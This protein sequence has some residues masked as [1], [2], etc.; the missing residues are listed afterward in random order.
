MCSWIF[1]EWIS[2]SPLACHRNQWL[3]LKIRHCFLY[4]TIQNVFLPH[5]LLLPSSHRLDC[6]SFLPFGLFSALIICPFSASF[7]FDLK[8]ACFPPFCCLNSTSSFRAGHLFHYSM[9]LFLMVMFNYSLLLYLH[10]F[11]LSSRLSA[12]QG[13][14]SSLSF[15]FPRTDLTLC[16]SLPPIHSTYIVCP[17]RWR[18]GDPQRWGQS[19][20]AVWL[21]RMG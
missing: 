20:L 7:S 21:F 3:S 1:I 15:S 6:K 4:S 17:A 5:P 19:C 9:K 13:Q 10:W 16:L 12:S 8:C 2:I 11:W 14:G 18:A